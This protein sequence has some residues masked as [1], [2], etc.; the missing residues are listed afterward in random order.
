MSLI[1]ILIVIGCGLYISAAAADESLYKSTAESALPTELTAKVGVNLGKHGTVT[2]HTAAEPIGRTDE[3]AANLDSLISNYQAQGLKINRLS[4]AW[5]TASGRLTV[6]NARPNF[7]AL[8]TSPN[9]LT[10]QKL[11]DRLTDATENTEQLAWHGQNGFSIAMEKPIDNTADN[12]RPSGDEALATESSSLVLA[13]R[14]HSSDGD[15]YEVAAV[16]QKLAYNDTD[17]ENN[18]DTAFGW[19]VKLAG[20]WRVGDWFTALSV[21][22]GDGIDNLILRRFNTDIGPAAANY[23]GRESF[24]IT[25]KIKYH[26]TENSDLHIQLGRYESGDADLTGIDTLDTVN[27]GYSWSPWPGSQFGVE[28]IG[29]DVDGE[30]GLEDSIEIKIEAQTEF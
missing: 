2:I 12:D 9:E 8:A 18:T 25:P 15:N 11:T 19:G 6:G 5:E 1:R 7:D 10:D 4:A 13:W 28:V 21:T 27:L 26:L 3:L 29:R 30:A 23:N 24:N 17:T 14:E 20:G 22:I 16:G